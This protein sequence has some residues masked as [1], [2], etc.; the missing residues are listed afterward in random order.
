MYADRSSIVNK[1][2]KTSVPIDIGMAKWGG[3][4]YPKSFVGPPF[5]LKRRDRDQIDWQKKELD[6]KKSE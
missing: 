2:G 5:A 6:N 4:L 3:P 1:L